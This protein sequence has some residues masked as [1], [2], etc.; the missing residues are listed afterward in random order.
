MASNP[1]SSVQSLSVW[2][3]VTPWT[4]AHQT[5][6]SLTISQSLP[7]FMST[8]SV[9]PS[10]HLI[11]CSPLLLLPLS[12]PASGTFP[13][14]WLFTS[15]GQSIGASA[16]ILPMSIQGWFPLGL[17][18]LI[19]LQSKELSRVFSS[20]TFQKHQFFGIQPSLWSSSCNSWLLPWK[21][22]CSRV[23]CSLHPWTWRGHRI[24][25]SPDTPIHRP[26]CLYLSI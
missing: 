21:Q 14:S 3:F 16:S 7:R 6:L 13:M 15:G 9:M 5:S 11:L 12:F 8:E 26:V 18:G 22:V 10:N 4:A 24:F 19:S 1:I 23:I 20:I 25:I 17:T 2:L